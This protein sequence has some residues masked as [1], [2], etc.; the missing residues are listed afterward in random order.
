MAM[1]PNPRNPL[2]IHTNGIGDS[3]L[4][5]PA[6][7]ALE[8]AYSGRLSILTRHSHVI[9]ELHDDG[10]FRSITEMPDFGRSKT[11]TRDLASILEKHDMFISLDHYVAPEHQTICRLRNGSYSIGLFPTYGHCVNRSINKHSVD[12]YFDIVTALF[13]DESICSYVHVPRV[14]SESVAIALGLVGERAVG[15]ILAVHSETGSNKRWTGSGFREVTRH[16]LSRVPASL[17]WVLD[18]H[19][20]DHW[21]DGLDSDRVIFVPRLRFDVRMAMMSLAN[22]FVGIDS[23]MLHLA[24]LFRVPSIALFT[25]TDSRRWGLRFAQGT[26]IQTANVP[27]TQ[28]IDAISEAI[29]RC[30]K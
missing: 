28:S 6:V 14:R 21:W 5:V 10:S 16:F 9:R 18:F 15:H 2:L 30:V 17:V 3:I 23:S 22:V 1:S 29:E 20:L 27:E 13:P 4:A 25:K 24:D 8:M 11:E 7:R 12:E 19:G 26:T